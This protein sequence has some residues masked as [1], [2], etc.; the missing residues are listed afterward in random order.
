MRV[1]ILCLALAAAL[2]ATAN[3]YGCEIGSVFAMYP[4]PLGLGIFALVE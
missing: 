2:A 3:A 4:D 1:G